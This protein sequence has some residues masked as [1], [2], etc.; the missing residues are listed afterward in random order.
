M[1]VVRSAIKVDAVESAYQNWSRLNFPRTEHAHLFFSFH[2]CVMYAADRER[3]GGRAQ[4]RKCLSV[5]LYIHLEIYKKKRRLFV[6]GLCQRYYSVKDE[7]A[8]KKKEIRIRKKKWR[9]PLCWQ[10]F[11]VTREGC[12]TIFAFCLP[13]CIIMR[14]H[15]VYDCFFFFL[16]HQHLTGREGALVGNETTSRQHLDVMLP[17]S[18]AGGPHQQKSAAKKYGGKRKQFWRNQVAHLDRSNE[19]NDPNRHLDEMTL[20]SY[21][22]KQSRPSQQLLSARRKL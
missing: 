20:M 19:L 1:T 10:Q 14:C 16:T 13:A 11:C 21:N 12:T 17:I 8:K 7:Q 4:Q 9:R 3:E 5:G 22:V 2:S 15:C 6:W 18:K